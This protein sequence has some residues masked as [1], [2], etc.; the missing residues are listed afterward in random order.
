MANCAS[1]NALSCSVMV[2]YLL[3]FGAASW[4]SSIVALQTSPTQRWRPRRIPVG[5]ELVGDGVCAQCH[6]A[7]TS[8]HLK[9][10]MSMAMETVAESKVLTANPAMTFR[11]GNYTYEIKR[12]EKESIYSV[13]DGKETISLPILYV[14]GEGK[15]GQTYILQYEGGL[16]E[17]LVSFYNEIKGLDFTIGAARGVPASLKQALGRRLP[18]NE[19]ADC[20]SCHST[21]GVS[22]G[23]IHFD[24]VIPGIR[25]ETCHGP[26]GRHAAAGKAGEPNAKLIFNPGRLNGDE[27]SQDFC[28]SCHRG[29]NE[30]TLLKGMEINNVRFQPYRIFHSKC[31]S[32]DRRISCTAC[33]DPHAPLK[34]DAAYYDAKCLACHATKDSSAE[35][36]AGQGTQAKIPGC[37][38]KSK[39]CTSCHMPKIGPAAAHF[40]FTDHYIRIAKPREAYPN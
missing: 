36:D 22:G 17:S 39:D 25:C 34:Q 1:K 27:L 12:K 26:G 29:N 35:S 5:A 30:F 4:A 7:K 11:I 2:V 31:Y 10:S 32:D 24:K 28:G 19:V 37:R 40:K 6:A 14:F 13:T 3:M 23:Q 16:Y 15:A 18:D 21:G 9:T 20:F 38:V 8:S 33:H